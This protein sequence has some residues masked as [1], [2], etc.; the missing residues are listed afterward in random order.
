[1]DPT[2]KGRTHF[3]LVDLAVVVVILAVLIGL[4]M[5]AL[6]KTREAAA[7]TQCINNLKQIG[8]A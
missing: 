2:G 4:W 3:R 1:M 7:R 6:Q 8:L 5:P